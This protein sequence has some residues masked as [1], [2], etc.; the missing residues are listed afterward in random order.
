MASR[1]EL[2]MMQDMMAMAKR[3]EKTTI[4]AYFQIG[5]F[6][7][8]RKSDFPGSFDSN[9]SSSR[10]C[11]AET[12]V[13][14]D[15]VRSEPSDSIRSRTEPSSFMSGIFCSEGLGRKELMFPRITELEMVLRRGP[16]R[17]LDWR[18][19]PF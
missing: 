18:M 6:L 19:L 16:N 8:N 17:V 10:Y 4:P 2:K 3:F 1:I 7:L 13:K 12:S 11:S 5:F 14:F 15:A 9:S